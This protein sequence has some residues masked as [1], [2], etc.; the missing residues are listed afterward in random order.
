MK[1]KVHSDEKMKLCR[2]G[3]IL[4]ED[5][6]V[7]G[8]DF[9]YL[10]FSA[11]TFEFVKCVTPVRI[12]YEN[13]VILLS[14]TAPFKTITYLCA[15]GF[16]VYFIEWILL[17]FGLL[18][19][20]PLRNTLLASLIILEISEE[21]DHAVELF[22]KNLA[23]IQM[24]ESSWVD[25]VNSVR[26]L[27]SGVSRNRLQSIINLLKI[28]PFFGILALIMVP[29]YIKLLTILLIWLVALSFHPFG[30][31]IR[32]QVITKYT[33]VND[34]Y[35]QPTSKAALVPYNSVSDP[36]S[37]M[38]KVT[39]AVASLTFSQS[40]PKIVKDVILFENQRWWLGLGFVPKFFLNGILI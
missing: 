23:F 14:W 22:Q 5:S 39:E 29:T 19:W 21:T 18:L 2:F 12:I 16:V 13:L 27:F 36:P 25:I 26:V 32:N 8:E 38:S 9:G 37:M 28:T 4:P 15:F 34:A 10:S 33:D 7:F 24:L 30:V 11:V 1:V 31:Q 3:A 6:K 20:T 17:I 40:Q 35:N